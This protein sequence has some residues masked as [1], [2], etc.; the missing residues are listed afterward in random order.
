MLA[1]V[2]SERW[3]VGVELDPVLASKAG[4]RCRHPVLC[5]DFLHAVKTLPPADVVFG[6]PP[7]VL[8]FFES[9]MAAVRR[10][11]RKSVQCGFLLPVYFF[12]T[13]RRCVRW[14]EDWHVS[15]NMLPRDLFPGLRL[16]ICFA[17][18]ERGRTGLTGFWLHKELQDL[19][20]A[21]VSTVASSRT[22]REI[23]RE[24]LDRLGGRA[25]LQD[26][27]AQ[28]AGNDH[29]LGTWWKAKVRQTLQRYF[30]RETR[31]VWST[32]HA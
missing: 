6:N 13:S 22:W 30:T 28:V 5:G 31:G 10:H 2:P 16:P 29:P 21:G 14:A 15:L 8:S 25:A 7:F 12:Q 4:D 17:E 9:L 11:A 19:R 24:S 18:F 20:D 3:A 26:V 32:R 1:A 27:Y 23:V